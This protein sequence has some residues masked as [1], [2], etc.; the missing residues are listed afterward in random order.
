MEKAEVKKG[1]FN[2]DLAVFR[3]YT[4]SGKGDNYLEYLGI[5]GIT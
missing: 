3:L 2:K 4:E 1:L 5:I